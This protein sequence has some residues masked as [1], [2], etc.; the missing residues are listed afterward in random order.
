VSSKVSEAVDKSRRAFLR[1][2]ILGPAGAGEAAV[3]GVAVLD[4]EACIAWNGVIC[5]SCRTACQEQAIRVDRRG[6][7]T[8][9]A[10]ACTGCGACVD[11]CPSRAIRLPGGP[12]PGL[13]ASPSPGTLPDLHS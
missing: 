4:R 1:G 9:V 12:Q 6:R 10:G 5:I 11:P 8:I 7:P 2:R 3:P 13:P